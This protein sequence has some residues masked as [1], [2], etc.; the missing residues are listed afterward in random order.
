MAGVYSALGWGV[1][2][3]PD[4]GQTWVHVGITGS[5]NVV[6]G[7]TKNVYAMLSGASGLGSVTNPNFELAPLPGTGT[8]TQPGTPAGMTNGAAQVA[9]TSDGVHNILVAGN[10]GAGLWRY[11]EP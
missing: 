4:Y 11:V 1:L 10:W 7:T 2:R 9:V 6:F 3:S 5:E 8:W